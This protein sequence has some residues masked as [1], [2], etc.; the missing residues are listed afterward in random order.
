MVGTPEYLAPEI[1][2]LKGHS[3]TVDWWAFGILIYEMIFGKT[4]FYHE[5]RSILFK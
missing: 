1:L 3:Y 5:N 4:P 2:A